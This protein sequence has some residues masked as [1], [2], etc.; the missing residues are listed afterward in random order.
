MPRD[1]EIIDYLLPR[2][3]AV[4]DTECFSN[5]WCIGFENTETGKRVVLEQYDGHVLD[6]ARLRDILQR[7]RIYTF[8][9]LNYDIPMICYAMQK[10]TT[11]AMLKKLNDFII[12]DNKLRGDKKLMPWEILDRFNI[13]VPKWLDHIDLFEVAPG[14]RL[15]LKKYGARMNMKRL[16]ETPIPFDK[17]LNLH[18][19]RVKVIDYMNNDLATTAELKR[20]LKSELAARAWMSKDLNFDVRSKSDAQMAEAQFKVK[21][22]K[23]TGERPDK[24]KVRSMRFRYEPPPFI[25]FRTKQL[26]DMFETI[27]STDFVIDATNKKN[28]KV[29]GVVK[30]PQA[31]KDIKLRIGETDYKMGIGGLHSKE[32]N[33]SFVADEKTIIKDRDVRAYYPRLMLAC[34]YE[35]DSLEGVFTPIFRESVDKRDVFKMKAQFLKDNGEP[36]EVWIEYDRNAGTFK[37]V[38]NGTF[39]KAGSPYS[40]M[41]APKM[42]IST[43]ITGQLCLLMLIERL[44]MAKVGFNVISANTDGIVTVIPK[45]HYGLFTAIVFDWEVD[46]TLQTEEVDYAG[47]YSRDV[48]SYIALVRDEKT[49]EVKKAKRKGLFAPAGL[50]DK[51]D[52]TYDICSTAVVDYL[53]KGHDIE[54]TIRR[55]ADI[56]QFVAVKQV[57]KSGA[58]LRDGEHLGRM[59]RWYIGEGVREAIYT[60]DKKRVAGTTGAVP[61]LDFPDE[62]PDDIDYEFYIRE[63]YA[64]LNDIGLSVR[65]P[66]SA[67]RTGYVLASLPKQKTL[68]IVDLATR[69]SLCSRATEKTVREAW[70]EYKRAPDGMRVCKAC[71]EERG[72]VDEEENEDAMAD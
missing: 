36:E 30:L 9:G 29:W 40:I 44:H 60:E 26:Q 7:F 62:F 6:R 46:C 5:Y 13:T 34:G 43:T 71:Q 21:Y 48:N 64:R 61:C 31:I 67:G 12:V 18:T 32:H 28:K 15:S 45:E 63:A 69:R 72:Y 39:G 11:C 10:G 14:V 53:M 22:E 47:V 37:I 66:R 24:P 27:C 19:D 20:R 33:R 54:R 3:E 23:I 51:H 2:N 68:H 50:Q 58:Y 55:C 4:T 49:G 52:P 35:P 65:D 1:T 38:N 70:I 59:I 8:N 56:T 25:K 16:Q 42:M 41:Y 17:P 57:G